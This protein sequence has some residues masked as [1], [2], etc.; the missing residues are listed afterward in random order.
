MPPWLNEE[1]NFYEV[2][3][4]LIDGEYIDLETIEIKGDQTYED[5]DLNDDGQLTNHEI[6]IYYT[7]FYQQQIDEV[8]F[9]PDY[10]IQARTFMLA[11]S[12]GK[13]PQ[14]TIVYPMPH[15][16]FYEPFFNSL[17]VFDIQV[18]EQDSFNAQSLQ[19]FSVTMYNKTDFL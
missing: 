19:Q 12:T 2:E 13:N 11:R 18:E 6:K 17:R 5:I 1:Y 16:M 4:T 10:S 3:L 8:E 14:V 7:K 9:N 15:K